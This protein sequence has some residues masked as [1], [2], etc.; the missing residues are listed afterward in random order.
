[1]GTINQPRTSQKTSKALEIHSK[2]SCELLIV[3]LLLATSMGS[4]IQLEGSDALGSSETGLSPETRDDLNHLQQTRGPLLKIPA[5][6]SSPPQSFYSSLNPEE[7]ITPTT[8]YIIHPRTGAC[9]A[10]PGPLHPLWSHFVALIMYETAKSRD[11]TNADSS[12]EASAAD[13]VDHYLANPIAFSRCLDNAYA[14]KRV[15]IR[16]PTSH[17]ML[18]VPEK[19]Y[20]DI[21]KSQNTLASIWTINK[22]R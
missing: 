10:A 5:T 17:M 1:M 6:M 3:F 18:A 8:A 7:L 4:S 22:N 20:L 21:G 12:W 16:A 2:T 9:M 19:A 15:Q 11:N 14:R 13:R